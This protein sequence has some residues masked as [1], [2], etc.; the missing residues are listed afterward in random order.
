MILKT[1]TLQT[2]KDEAALNH[3]YLFVN[4]IL[5]F[6][7]M[8]CAYERPRIIIIALMLPHVKNV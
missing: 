4:V 5:I 7:M 6:L 1:Y 3:R 2:V 8:T